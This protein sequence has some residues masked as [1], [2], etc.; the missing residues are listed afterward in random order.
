MTGSSD[1]GLLEG[2]ADFPWADLQA[3]FGQASA[4]PD[5]LRA[6]ASGDEEAVWDLCGQVHHQG[7][8]CPCSCRSA[9]GPAF[10]RES[11][12]DVGDPYGCPFRRRQ[13]QSGAPSGAPG[14]LARCGAPLYI[15]AHR[16]AQHPYWT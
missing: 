5:L 6:V 13:R 8:A 4:F 1:A 14:I 3:C 7:E 9:P 2:L 15:T 16:W 11:R 10:P 12:P